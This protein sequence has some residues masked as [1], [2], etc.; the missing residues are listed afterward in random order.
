MN[1]GGRSGPAG[2]DGAGDASLQADA[3]PFPT[4]PK[5]QA[6]FVALSCAVPPELAALV[7]SLAFGAR[8]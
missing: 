3:F 4:L 7:A 5:L 2:K 1:G 6:Q 8:P